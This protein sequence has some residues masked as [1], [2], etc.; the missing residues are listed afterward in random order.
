M[1][2]PEIKK[3]AV[4]YFDVTSGIRRPSAEVV[5]RYNHVPKLFNVNCMIASVS[6][7]R[8]AIGS[9]DKVSL[10]DCINHVPGCVPSGGEFI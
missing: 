6:A 7:S 5:V 9:S 4:A 10:K 1:I 3:I 8:L 2:S